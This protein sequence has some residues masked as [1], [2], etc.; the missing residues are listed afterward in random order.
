MDVPVHFLE[1]PARSIA[2]HIAM[3]SDEVRSMEKRRIEVFIRCRKGSDLHETVRFAVETAL[4][5][6][7]PKLGGS[8]G[9][10]PYPKG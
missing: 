3:H 2:K 10:G 7:R 8:I 9:I 6:N 1:A 5:L 4:N